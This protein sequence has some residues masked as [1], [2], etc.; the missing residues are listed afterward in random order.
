MKPLPMSPN[1]RY[2]SLRAV[3][4][5]RPSTSCFTLA[6][7]TWMPGTS[8]GM[9]NSRRERRSASIPRLK[10]TTR[11]AAVLLLDRL[12]VEC[13]VQVRQAFKHRS[14]GAVGSDAGQGFGGEDFAGAAAV[15]GLLLA[16]ECQLAGARCDVDIADPVDDLVR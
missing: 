7:K 5:S 16:S 14:G 4:L 8:P 11:A 15:D 9:T 1:T 2:P 12:G 10:R 3:H 13:A 6:L